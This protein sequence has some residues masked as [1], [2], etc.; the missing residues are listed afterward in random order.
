MY[1][2][3]T[4]S[5]EAFNIQHSRPNIE[6]KARRGLA[7]CTIPAWSLADLGAVLVRGQKG[8]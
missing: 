2:V 5:L 4:A 6:A 1:Y 8:V 7:N 3:P